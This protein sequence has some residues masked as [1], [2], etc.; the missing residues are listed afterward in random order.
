MERLRIT[1]NHIVGAEGT[2]AEASSNREATFNGKV[3][4]CNKF[5]V[6]LSPRNM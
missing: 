5:C 4:F 2:E 3:T 6:V 1:K